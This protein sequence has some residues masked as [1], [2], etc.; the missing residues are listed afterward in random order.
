MPVRKLS[1]REFRSL[2]ISYPDSLDLIRDFSKFRS[3]AADTSMKFSRADIK[4][5]ISV[6]KKCTS[7]ISSSKITVGFPNESF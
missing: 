1:H 3:T 7:G 6:L 4:L 5:D 2:A